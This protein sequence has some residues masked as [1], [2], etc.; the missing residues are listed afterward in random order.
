M[1]L[2]VLIFA[3]NFVFMITANF[4]EIGLINYVTTGVRLMSS[5]GSNKPQHVIAFLLLT[6]FDREVKKPSST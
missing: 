2:L 3:S 4:F 5:C 6:T 1:I